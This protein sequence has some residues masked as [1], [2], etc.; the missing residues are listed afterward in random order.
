MPPC[1]DRWAAMPRTSAMD[2]LSAPGSPNDT[3]PAECV[4]TA[5]LT[6]WPTTLSAEKGSSGVAHPKMKTFRD[7][8]HAAFG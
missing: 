8:H 1:T 3:R 5:W 4:S 2:S 6:S 7:A